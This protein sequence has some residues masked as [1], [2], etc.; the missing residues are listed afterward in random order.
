MLP[1]FV[2][3]SPVGKRKGLLE[4]RAS[5]GRDDGPGV[6]SGRAVLVG[7]MMSARAVA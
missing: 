7:L 3:S 2:M 6:V 1:A 5:F 4:S